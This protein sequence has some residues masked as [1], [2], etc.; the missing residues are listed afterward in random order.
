MVVLPFTGTS[1][2]AAHT[3]ELQPGCLDRVLAGNMPAMST[4]G[5]KILLFGEQKGYELG[6]SKSRLGLRHTTYLMFDSL[7]GEMVYKI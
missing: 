5:E 3:T 1:V 6:V 7:R 2:S 4:V